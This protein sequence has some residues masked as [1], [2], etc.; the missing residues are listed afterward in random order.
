EDRAILTRRQTTGISMLW[1]LPNEARSMEEL[2]LLANV[3]SGHQRDYSGAV[4]PQTPERLQ[5]SY[6]TLRQR[7]PHDLQVLPTDVITWHLRE[8]KASEVSG[9]WSAAIFHW[10]Q[11][12]KLKPDEQTFHTHLNHALEQMNRTNPLLTH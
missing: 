6:Q 7:H 9:Q 8:A 4:L 3:L 1:V 11:L 5:E 2:A 12:L 10:N